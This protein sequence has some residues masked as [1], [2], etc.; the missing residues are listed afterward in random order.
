MDDLVAKSAGVAPWRKPDAEPV[1]DGGAE[2][3]TEN[4]DGKEKHGV[5]EEDALAPCGKIE[6]AGEEHD[7]AG[8]SSKIALNG[9]KEQGDAAQ[10]E[11]GEKEGDAFLPEVGRVGKVGGKV[12]DEEQL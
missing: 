2:V 12:D 7:E 1:V 11:G 6:D 10:E 9:E 8:G 3:V 5:A 4:C